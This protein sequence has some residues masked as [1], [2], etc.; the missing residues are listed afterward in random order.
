MSPPAYL[1]ICAITIFV[2][3]YTMVLK[4]LLAVF[5]THD[6]RVEGIMYVFNDFQLTTESPAYTVCPPLHGL[7]IQP[8]AM[9]SM[10]TRL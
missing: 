8:P 4:S 6:E 10:R 5:A 3:L 7:L 9:T 2:Q 1:W